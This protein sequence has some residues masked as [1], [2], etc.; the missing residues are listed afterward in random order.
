MRAPAFWS[1]GKG[2]L[3][4]A[5]LSPLGMLYGCG[6]GARQVFVKPWQCPVPVICVGNLIAGGTGKTPVVMDLASR[7]LARGG[8]PHL[9]SRGYGGTEKGPL[10]VFA[11]R[12][13]ARQVGDE[14]LLLS[15]IA[16]VWVATNRQDACRTATVG[17]ATCMIFDDGFQDP[18]VIRDLSLVIVDGGYGFGNEHMIPAGPLREPIVKGLDRANA[19][20]VIG[21]DTCGVIERIAGRCPVLRA[22]LKPGAEAAVLKGQPVFAFAGIGRPE[23]FFDTLRQAGCDVRG[24]RVFDDHHNFTRTELDALKADANR[25]G[26]KLVT[27]AKD[28]IRIPQQARNG[29][30]VLTVDLV[31]EDESAINAL[32]EP[33]VRHG[34]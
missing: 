12:H 1:R 4:G 22:S 18:S 2:G 20:I 26:L 23:K 28:L 25:D 8:R 17:G 3:L 16:P 30:A 24:T 10:Q 14:A 29:I 11:D 19:V 6:T 31:W 5:L 34:V 15:A 13:D 32:L 7:L 27:T 21:E 9:V 33:V